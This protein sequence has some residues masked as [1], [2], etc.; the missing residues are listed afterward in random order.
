ML[1]ATGVAL[2]TSARAM[3][4]AG[5]LRTG[6]SIKLMQPDPDRPGGAAGTNLRCGGAFSGFNPSGSPILA[7]VSDALTR[8]HRTFV[9]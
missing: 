8:P 5:D 7:G 4:V 2:L 9:L 6:R 3:L 1:R